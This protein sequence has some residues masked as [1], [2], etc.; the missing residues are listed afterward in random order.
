MNRSIVA[1]LA[2]AVTAS[3]GDG[4]T[5]PGDLAASGTVAFSYNG[6][7]LLA[8]GSYSATGGMPLTSNDIESHTWAAGY[9]DPDENN[10]LA[11]M[12]SVSRSSRYDWAL[13]YFDRSTAG[14]STID[15]D[16]T[17]NACAGMVFWYNQSDGSATAGEVYCGLE[18]GTMTI[19]T[20]SN[21]RATGTFSG[22]GTC[23]TLDAVT[24]SSFTVTNGTFDVPIVTDPG[25][26]TG[27]MIRNQR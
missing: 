2:L 1:L 27:L 3:C 11:V 10:N 18:T 14:T 21:T 13:M 26:G 25:V 8:A 7:S 19:A 15:I 24:E 4:G 22:T 5:D 23:F 12:G 16:C 9:R 20:I 6:G 17:A